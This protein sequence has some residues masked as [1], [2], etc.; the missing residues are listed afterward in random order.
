MLLFFS[1]VRPYVPS[2]GLI[3]YWGFYG[4]ANDESGNN[5]HGIP[6]NLVSTVDRFGN[7]NSAY[8]F[9]GKN[10]RIDVPNAF[11]NIGWNTFTIS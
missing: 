4:N 7:E 8:Q 6:A 1:Q 11:F 5:N 3:G 9:N 2:N 10:S